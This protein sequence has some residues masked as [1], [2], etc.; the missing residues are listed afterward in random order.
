[1]NSGCWNK[2]SS[3]STNALAR[4]LERL[5]VSSMTSACWNQCSPCTTKSLIRLLVRSLCA[6]MNSGCCHG[7]S[8]LS[9]NSLNRSLVP[10]FFSFA[11]LLRSS[12]DTEPTNSLMMLLALVH[13]SQLPKKDQ[14]MEKFSFH[15]F[16]YNSVC[17]LTPVC[18]QLHSAYG[19]PHMRTF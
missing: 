4:L 18:A 17:V 7:C 11:A 6:L 1:M 15:N 13:I 10:A 9:A 3:I 5:L 14:M 8:P 12:N 19:D 2:C 16:A